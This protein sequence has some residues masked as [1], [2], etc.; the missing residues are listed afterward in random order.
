MRKNLSGDALL[1]MP[2]PEL[3]LH[4]ILSVSHFIL[5]HPGRRKV[6]EDCV[7]P[8]HVNGHFAQ[9]YVVC[10]G[11]GGG[12]RGDIASAMICRSLGHQLSLADKVDEQAIEET[13][14][15][16]EAELRDHSTEFPE[17]RGMATTVV[18]FHPTSETEGLVYWVGDSRLYHLR[19]GE[20]LFKTKDHSLVQMMIDN[21][22]ITEEQAEKNSARNVILQAI[23][24]SKRQATPE[25]HRLTDI[26]SGDRIL[27]MTDGILEGCSENQLVKL[28]KGDSKKA[29]SEIRSLCE[30]KS[31]DNFS[32][33]AIEIEEEK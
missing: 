4:T 7:F 24:D 18:G 2:L 3:K 33:I 22:E 17:S 12:N 23:S 9:T 8:E 21:G 11:V 6:N 16:A 20:I 19:D 29:T 15:A 26:Q 28:F 25:I 13:L 5:S 30:D 32:M 31:S 14:N 27:L 1:L 10:D